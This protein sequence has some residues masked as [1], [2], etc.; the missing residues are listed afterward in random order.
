M[1]LPAVVFLWF[2][3]ACWC[4]AD[5]YKWTDENGKVHYSNVKPENYDTEQVDKPINSYTHQAVPDSHYYTP[6]PIDYPKRV[7][8]YSTSWCGYCKKARQYFESQGIAYNERDIETST[9]A[10]QEYEQLGASGIP[11]LLIGNDTMNGWN[12]ARFE[13]KYRQ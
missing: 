11:F 10:R 12:P 2:C 13:K 4:Q 8:M 9:R 6:P 7:V 5:I 1:K 3:A